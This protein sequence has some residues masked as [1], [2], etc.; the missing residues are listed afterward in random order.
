MYHIWNLE[1]FVNKIISLNKQAVK[2]IELGAFKEALG[3]LT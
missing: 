1:H 3:L 2:Q